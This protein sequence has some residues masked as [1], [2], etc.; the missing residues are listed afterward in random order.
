MLHNNRTEK[1]HDRLNKVRAKEICAVY[2]HAHHIIA[3][4]KNTHLYTQNS[5]SRLRD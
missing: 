3:V 1:N 5:F 2:V 4:Y